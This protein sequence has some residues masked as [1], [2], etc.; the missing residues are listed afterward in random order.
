MNQ[1]D[2]IDDIHAH[3][4][5]LQALL[6]NWVTNSKMATINIQHRRPFF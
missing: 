3:A 2:I 1:Y 6:K 4:D 5:I